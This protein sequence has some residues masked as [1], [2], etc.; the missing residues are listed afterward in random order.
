MEYSKIKIALVYILIIKVISIYILHSKMY[1]KLYNVNKDKTST[2]MYLS[3]I[4]S[5]HN[6]TSTTIFS[7]ESYAMH[8]QNI[9]KISPLETTH[10]LERCGENVPWDINLEKRAASYLRKL[11]GRCLADMKDKRNNNNALFGVNGKI[12][13]SFEKCPCSVPT[14]NC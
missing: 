5:T 11:K 8:G 1:P 14:G 10:H 3:K 12:L 7:L 9:T 4:N 13:R 2:G 6:Q